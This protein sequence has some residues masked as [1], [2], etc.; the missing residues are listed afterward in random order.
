MTRKLL[1]LVVL[2]LALLGAV[3]WWAVRGGS[4]RGLERAE[5]NGASLTNAAKAQLAT[6]PQPLEARGAEKEEAAVGGG[7]LRILVLDE[8]THAPIPELRLVAYRERGGIKELGQAKTDAQGRAELRDLEAN[9]ILVRVERKPPHAEATGAVWLI[10]GSTKELEIRVGEGGSV[11]GRVVDDQGA[12]LSGATVYVS[13]GR[14]HSES[15]TPDAT[16]GA[17]GRF[18]VTCVSNQP[19]SVW[20]VD[21]EMRP[22][23]W[24]GALI[25]SWFDGMSARRA[26]LVLP[27]KE[28]DLGDVAIERKSDYFGRVVD[29]HGSPV[30]GAVLSRHF[31]RRQ[32][33]GSRAEKQ[34]LR[35]EWTPVGATG[36]VLHPDE[37][38]TDASG[39]FEWHARASGAEVI[40]QT[41][42][43]QAQEFRL[44]A[45]KPGARGEAIELRLD[46]LTRIEFALVD[47]QGAA[48]CEREKIL[49]VAGFDPNGK[50]S[51]GAG[52][53][54]ADGLWRVDLPGDAATIA[55]LELE[56]GGYESM[57]AE[58]GGT[59]VDGARLHYVLSELPVIRVQL[60]REES[61]AKPGAPVQ[62]ALRACM[63]DPARRAKFAGAGCCGLGTTSIE[64]WDGE[65]R[66]IELRVKR[67]AP[68]WIYVRGPQREPRANSFSSVGYAG[69]ELSSG[70]WL[71]VAT[72]GP[73]VPGSDTHDL[74]LDPADFVKPPAAAEAAGEPPER[75]APGEDHAA[76][77]QARIVDARTGNGVG[78]AQLEFQL[79]QQPAPSKARGASAFPGAD[80]E[81][82]DF[83]LASGAWKVNVWKQGFRSRDLGLQSIA[84]DARV[85]LGTIALEPL[86]SHRGR[87]LHFDD[88]PVAGG[89]VW[90]SP[91]PPGGSTEHVL[92]RTQSDG[93]FELTGELPSKMLLRLSSRIELDGREYLELQPLVLD[94]WPEDESRELRIDTNR[95]QAIS[96]EGLEPGEADLLPCVC[97]APGEP[98]AICDHRSGTPPPHV[99]LT[100]GTPTDDRRPHRTYMFLLPAG[101]YVVWGSSLMKELPPTE[102]GI[103]DGTTTDE[104]TITAH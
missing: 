21:G 42:A 7:T 25:D 14:S 44:P 52:T 79:Q 66:A 9:T 96:I 73:F 8:Q 70:A 17:E 40:V 1:P 3:A 62:V 11:V 4:A 58:V 2:V 43:G 75:L 91:F 32:G 15:D 68:F 71:D 37:R 92:G 72:F 97:L 12:P 89:Y 16:T 82:R 54:A 99:W 81:L 101:H 22:E 46:A 38:L 24:R 48:L 88:Q 19:E 102:F 78:G 103:W 98:A 100:A 87:L 61:A 76:Y 13:G 77:I 80:G 63:A 50:R 95:F 64:T 74:L 55:E 86:P 104:L 56:L 45:L 18:R 31:Q 94:L 33:R 47:T 6:E 36:F 5:N 26:A 35:P 57:H 90:A 85:D 41:P 27:G 28:C 93:S 60:R 53:C 39:G 49:S 84:R 59:L 67:H 23:R 65:P 34:E 69:E 83:R 10:A 51:A 29:A 20:I 30:A